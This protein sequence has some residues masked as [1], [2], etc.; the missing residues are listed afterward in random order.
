MWRPSEQPGSIPLSAGFLTTE[1]ADSSSQRTSIDLKP[2]LTFL[3]SRIDK[4]ESN[5]A[6]VAKIND[7]LHKRITA[8]E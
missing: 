6:N 8:H 4:T 3:L 2:D 1:F 7:L 5:I